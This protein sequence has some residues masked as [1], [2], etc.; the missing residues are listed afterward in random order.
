[1]MQIDLQSSFLVGSTMATL[2]RR[3]LL[4]ASPDWLARTR[5]VVLAFSAIV[6]AP[7]W[8]YITLRWTP[9]E[10]MYIWDLATV[11]TWLL[12]LFLP[13]ISLG[14]LVGFEMTRR[15]LH[16]GHQ[17]GALA[18]PRGRHP[19]ED[20]HGVRH[21]AALTDD[22][23]HIFLRHLQAQVH[24]RAAPCLADMNLH[25][26]IHQRASNKLD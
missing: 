3:R 8:L 1:M 9:W 20:P 15:L 24:I 5:I 2:A 7:V 14:A 11:P 23:A 21:P 25:G 19:Q 22:P 18:F 13:L 4:A 10:T 6:F 16:G 17:G 26:V 12:A